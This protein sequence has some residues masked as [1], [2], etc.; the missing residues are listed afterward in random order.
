[1]LF[2]ILSIIFAIIIIVLAILMTVFIVKYYNVNK[3]LLTGI[4]T[5]EESPSVITSRQ[6]YIGIP[7]SSSENSDIV[8][9][10]KLINELL[11]LLKTDVLCKNKELLLQ[12]IDILDMLEGS[13]CNFTD[14][15]SV[16]E[17]NP[18][19]NSDVI[20]KLGEFTKLVCKDGKL[21]K[22]DSKMLIRNLIDAIC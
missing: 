6:N 9:L 12:Q 15:I 21:N 18:Y 2:Q 13:D 4:P 10:V 17:N 19:I 14:A 7:I 5:I 20:Q 22:E 11:L 16:D 8:S 3:L 1:M